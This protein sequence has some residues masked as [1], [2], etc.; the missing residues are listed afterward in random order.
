[1]DKLLIAPSISPISIAFAVP[2]ACEAVPI[3]I[4]FATGLVIL[5]ILQTTSASM[6]PR[7]PVMI[8]TATVIVT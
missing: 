6:F 5:K 8:I 4:P 1:M 7:T 3:P 2:M